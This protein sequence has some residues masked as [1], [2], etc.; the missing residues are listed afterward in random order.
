MT[1]PLG[2]PN[3]R[4]RKCNYGYINLW[5]DDVGSTYW[6]KVAKL[7]V[8]WG[9]DDIGFGGKRIQGNVHTIKSYL[10]LCSRPA[11]T[12]I[13]GINVHNVTKRLLII[14]PI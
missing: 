9:M 10:L 8:S 4:Y 11:Q 2:S 12:Q 7:A 13:Y 5:G 14:H 6:I 1:I 3:C